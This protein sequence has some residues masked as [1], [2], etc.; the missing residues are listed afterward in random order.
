M[1]RETD[2]EWRV[3]GVCD[4]EEFIAQFIRRR[5]GLHKEN[6]LTVNLNAVNAE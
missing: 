1:E 4:G 2:G 5:D 6:G 3:M